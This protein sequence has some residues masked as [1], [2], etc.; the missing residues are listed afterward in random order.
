MNQENRPPN[1][2]KPQPDSIS[3]K[4]IEVVSLR[5]HGR[6]TAKNLDFTADFLILRQLSHTV[7]ILNRAGLGIHAHIPLLQGKISLSGSLQDGRSVRVESLYILHSNESIVEIAP[8]NCAVEIGERPTSR[9]LRAKYTLTGLYYGDLACDH[10]DWTIQICANSESMANAR[11][12]KA[13]NIPLDGATLTLSCLSKD[14]RESDYDDFADS[15]F[16][17]MALASG[18]GVTSHRWIYSFSDGQE[19]ELW[20]PRMGDDIGPGPIVAHT[21]FGLFLKECLP[22]WQQ[23]SDDD[24]HIMSVAILHLNTAGSGFL[25]NR[26]LQVSQIWE[27]L[28]AKWGTKK[29]M[30]AEILQ[31]KNELKSFLRKWR[32]EKPGCDPDGT[33]SCRV[34]TSMDWITLRSRMNSMIELF[35][36]QDR[37]IGL[38][39][40]KL[41]DAR[42]KAAHSISLGASD[43]NTE[44]IL[45]LLLSAQTGI[46][47]LLL[48]KLNYSGSVIFRDNGW[49]VNKGIEFFFAH[50]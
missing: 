36:L 22:S 46:Q 8:M 7:F 24:L 43:G 50:T 27:L 9:P 25:D 15:L 3:A 2:S 1:I 41:K 35:G 10:Q 14:K 6:F 49:R 23:L 33:I 34:L 11:A 19:L 13:L 20:R 48:R 21:D 26:L 4:R 17:L 44:D 18:N 42:D 31:L 37:L 16:R 38:D 29:I 32:D 39:F 12:S 47:L 28:A 5:G 40:A 30:P 45:Q